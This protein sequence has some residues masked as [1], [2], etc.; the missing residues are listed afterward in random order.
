MFG[1]ADE[2][3]GPNYPRRSPVETGTIIDNTS[4]NVPARMMEQPAKNIDPDVVAI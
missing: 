1:L 2:Y 3:S 4:D